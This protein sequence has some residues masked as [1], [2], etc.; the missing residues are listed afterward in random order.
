MD[1]FIFVLSHFCCDLCG[2]VVCNSECRF[3]VHMRGLSEPIS[4][5]GEKLKKK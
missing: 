2:G 3:R 4:V 1:Y 5:L